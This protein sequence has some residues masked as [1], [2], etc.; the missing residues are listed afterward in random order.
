MRKNE[1]SVYP[2]EIF[3]KC[4]GIKEAFMQYSDCFDLGLYDFIE[5]YGKCIGKYTIDILEDFDL[6]PEE[7]DIK[8]WQGIFLDTD[9]RALFLRLEDLKFDVEKGNTYEGHTA[10]VKICLTEQIDNNKF[11]D[12]LVSSIFILRKEEEIAK[13]YLAQDFSIWLKYPLYDMNVVLTGRPFVKKSNRDDDGKKSLF[14]FVKSI[15][16]DE[17]IPDDAYP[18]L[19]GPY[20]AVCKWPSK[21]FFSILSSTRGGLSDRRFFPISDREFRTLSYDIL[22]L[23]ENFDFPEGSD[24][25]PMNIPVNII[26]SY[27]INRMFY[28]R[29]NGASSRINHVFCWLMY[30]LTAVASQGLTEKILSRLPKIDVDDCERVVKEIGMK[31]CSYFW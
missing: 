7:Y 23:S 15:G 17:V 4:N 12:E 20:E 28:E 24:N 22:S 21:V 1:R 31:Q 2:A 25:H 14:A 8:E 29:E 26:Q 18:S 30:S 6:E 13:N 19:S 5:K 3:R 27:I 10:S 16:K 9:Y 11:S